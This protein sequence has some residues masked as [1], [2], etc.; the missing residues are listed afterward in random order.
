ME[1]KRNSFLRSQLIIVTQVIICALALGFAFAA[2][3]IGGELYA[4]A[5]SWYFDSYNASLFTGGEMPALPFTEE[6]KISET[7]LISPEAP[8]DPPVARATSPAQIPML[9]G[10]LH[11]LP[12]PEAP[13]TIPLRLLSFPRL[14]RRAFSFAEFSVQWSVVSDQNCG[15]KPFCFRLTSMI[16]DSPSCREVFYPWTPSPTSR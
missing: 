4:A 9:P 15:R 8:S 6:A 11:A 7:S 2:K 10:S 14:P 13:A 1:N 5:A 3:A 16:N 12:L